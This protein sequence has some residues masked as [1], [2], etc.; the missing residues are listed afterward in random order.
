MVLNFDGG[1][2][3]HLFFRGRSIYDVT[4]KRGKKKKQSS[5]TFHF[6]IM[7]NSSFSLDPSLFSDFSMNYDLQSMKELISLR[8]CFAGQGFFS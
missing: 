4:Q 1:Q 7:Y 5:I 8:P 6:T 2:F 3:C